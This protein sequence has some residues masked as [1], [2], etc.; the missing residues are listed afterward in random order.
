[1][2]DEEEWVPEH[3]FSSLTK[4]IK[5]LDI[6]NIKVSQSMEKK[7]QENRQCIKVYGHSESNEDSLTHF[8]N[9]KGP[10]FRGFTNDS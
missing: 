2:I 10:H 5:L 9:N 4:S 3:C 7:H 6:S 8:V 1:M